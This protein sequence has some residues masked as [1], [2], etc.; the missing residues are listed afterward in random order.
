[1][2]EELHPHPI[3]NDKV[4]TDNGGY[5]NQK[6]IVVIVLDGVKYLRTIN[7]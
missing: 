5:W 7:Y 1:M 3:P 6:A 4:C 2:P